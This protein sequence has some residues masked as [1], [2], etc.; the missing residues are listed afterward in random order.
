ML[1]N[2]E[3]MQQKNTEQISSVNGN[4]VTTIL[5]NGNEKIQS[6]SGTNITKVHLANSKP[7]FDKN[8]DV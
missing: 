6:K 7:S 8:S 2:T 1:H 5:K 3:A 4:F